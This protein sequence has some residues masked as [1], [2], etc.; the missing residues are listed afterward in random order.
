MSDTSIP[1]DDTV[2][3]DVSAPTTDDSE[4]PEL[5][6]DRRFAFLSRHIAGFRALRLGG[7]FTVAAAIVVAIIWWVQLTLLWG[8]RAQG[9]GKVGLGGCLGE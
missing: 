1:E 5:A 9:V 6:T 7:V 2:T 3:D 8:G 4:T